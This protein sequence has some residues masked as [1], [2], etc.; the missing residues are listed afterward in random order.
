MTMMSRSK[1]W[2]TAFAVAAMAVG[3]G[4]A[5]ADIIRSAVFTSDHCTGGC[6]VSTTNPGALLT[7]T[8]HEN[9]TLDFSIQTAPNYVIVG[10]GFEASFAFN[11]VGN[12]TITYSSIIPTLTYSI[13]GGISPQQ[14][15]GSLMVDGFGNFEYGI[16]VINNGFG[17]NA[18][19]TLS[20]R[21]SGA[22]LDI[23]DLAELSTG[24]SP[25]A[26]FALDV[27]HTV[28]GV[29]TTGAIDISLVLTPGQQCFPGPCTTAIPEPGSLMVLGTTLIVLGGISY[30]IRRRRED[31]V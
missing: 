2:A 8:D 25:P 17:N 26:F 28:G 15:A 13:P 31:E 10:S 23:T 12:P 7:V 1:F 4:R 18:G 20:F 24:G 22:G 29:T 27:A 16:D 30:V 14:N 19:S 6:G 9:G 5:Q 21:I 3:I 11:L